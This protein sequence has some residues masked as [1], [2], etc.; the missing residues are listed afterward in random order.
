MLIEIIVI[1]IFTLSLW[2]TYSLLNI[3][4][5]LEVIKNL[6]ITKRLEFRPIIFI[7][8]KSF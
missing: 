1:L 3:D 2:K 7:L 6:K 8:Y 4:F 5:Y